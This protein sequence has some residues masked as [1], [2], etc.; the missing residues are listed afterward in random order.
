MNAG[1]PTAVMRWSANT[2]HELRLVGVA[3][4]F[5]T[6]MPVPVERFD[7]AWL[8]DSARH[9]PLVG[10]LVGSFG[11]GV[12][13]ATAALWALPIAV[14]LS[15]A[16]TIWLTG[17]FHE[18]GLADTCDGLG[19][20]VSRDKALAIMKDS[21][22]GTHGVL[23]LLLVLALKAAAL[24][25]LAQASVF[26]A[27]TALVFAHGVSRVCAVVLLA[28]LPYAGDPAQAKAKPL[29][30]RTGRFGAAV[31]V[32]WSVAFAVAFSISMADLLTPARVAL[33]L[34]GASMVTLACAAW[35][36]RRLGGYTGDA[37]GAT[38]QASELAIYLALAAWPLAGSQP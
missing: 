13:W 37:L 34:A 27:A 5:L 36:R 10:A 4:Q 22:L 6:R 35:L 38:Q 15:M 26:L 16:A 12:L 33:S 20:A 11:A 32:V 3:L 19:G 29:A 18:D 8:N 17:G 21:R 14:L 2:L 31:A 24:W 28:V 9:F 30:Q 7:P 25:S 23:G 1:R